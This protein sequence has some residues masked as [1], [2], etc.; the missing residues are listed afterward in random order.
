MLS[1]RIISTLKFF[2]LQDYPLTS[3]ELWRYLISDPEALKENLD[4]NFELIGAESIAPAPVHYDTLLTALDALVREQR[5]C[6]KNGFYYLPERKQLVG[7]RLVNY[8][9]GIRR[10]RFIRRYLKFTKHI[11]FIR[12]IS[13]AG[14]QALGLKRKSSDIDLLI[15]TDGRFMW[16]ARIFLSA[17]F[18]ILGVRRYKNKISNRFCLNHYFANLDIKTSRNLYT[19]LEYTKLRHVVYPQSLGDFQRRNQNWIKTFFPNVRFPELRV[20]KQSTL[21]RL[22][23]GLLDNR[24]GLWLN[25]QAGKLQ[26]RRIRQDKYILATEDEL[27]FHPNS[28][29]EN[30]LAAM[31]GK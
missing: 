26:L 16:M 5:V 22:L 6:G 7:K 17:Y 4:E 1:E 12:S 18:Q 8:R 20:R 31:F 21:Q 25:S 10:E 11:P 27:S 13:I 30:L 23:E 28:K 9:Y 24:L 15:L 14:S 3:Y 19:A 2:D 29:Q